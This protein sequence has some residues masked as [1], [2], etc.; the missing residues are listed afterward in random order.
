MY[1]KAMLVPLALVISACGTQPLPVVV[2]FPQPPANDMIVPVMLVPLKEPATAVD[3]LHNAI[4]NF[5]ACHANSSTLS[6]L[7][8][9][10]R[11]Q[12][13]IK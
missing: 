1:L 9:W 7:E 13:G 10:V 12:E 3:A 6:N 4:Q 5:G 11:N 8:D 2:P